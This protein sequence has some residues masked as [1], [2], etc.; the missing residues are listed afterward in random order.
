MATGYYRIATG[1]KTSWAVNANWYSGLTGTTSVAYPNGANQIAYIGNNLLANKTAYLN[2]NVTAGI[3]LSALYINSQNAVGNLAGDPGAMIVGNNLTMTAATSGLCEI[4]ALA[5]AP[6]M[7]FGQGWIGEGI[8]LFIN[9]ANT[10]ITNQS[11]G[12]MAFHDADDHMYLTNLCSILYVNAAS[13]GTIYFE[14]SLNYTGTSYA[15]VDVT[16]TGIGWVQWGNQSPLYESTTFGNV[17]L[18]VSRGRFAFNHNRARRLDDSTFAAGIRFSNAV[19]N[20]PIIVD[21]WYEYLTNSSLSL[22]S[23]PGNTFY[24]TFPGSANAT[25][26]GTW[27]MY[28]GTYDLNIQGS[29]FTI[30]GS[31]ASNYWGDLVKNGNGTLALT[32]N[33]PGIASYTQNAGTT[34]LAAENSGTPNQISNVYSVVLNGGYMN[35]FGAAGAYVWDRTVTGTGGGLT[36][37]N[38]N[39]TISGN[40]SGFT[41][42]FGTYSTNT[43]GTSVI[44]SFS[45]ANSFPKGNQNFYASNS[46]APATHTL[47]YNGTGAD[48]T[49]SATYTFTPDSNQSMTAVLWNANTAGRTLTFSG[50]MTHIRNTNAVTLQITSEAAAGL[51]TIS[52]V[53]SQSATGLLSVNKTGA[54]T[55]VLSGNNTHSGGSSVTTGK[56]VAAKKT[57]LGTGRVIVSGSLQC[58]DTT[59]DVAKLASVSSFTSSGGRLILGA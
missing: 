5:G 47:K 10:R 36:I 14:K 7:R 20:E 31:A 30:G 51:L 57:A 45:N 38:P 8:K 2:V 32:A 55:A 43:I 23:S 46:T 19:A 6:N 29:T 49:T 48:V 4:V 40:L 17:G 21:A 54:G 3:T 59:T 42:A 50:P 13:A 22:Y 39:I 18:G 28:G 11:N 26:N 37:G 15:F 33:S 27:Y 44:V 12:L 16:S 52:G 24:L 58:T 53:L 9:G 34:R 56:L 41:G 1:A 35:V 25:F